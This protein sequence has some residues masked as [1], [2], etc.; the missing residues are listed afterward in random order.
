[1]KT[2]N[3]LV[4]GDVLYVLYF[5][6]EENRF[7]TY[8]LH[9]DKVTY[10][11]DDEECEDVKV[12]YECNPLTHKYVIW[13]GVALTEINESFY[14]IRDGLFVSTNKDDIIQHLKEYQ[15][16]LNDIINYANENL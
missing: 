15:S 5:K 1:M 16:R 3:E 11:Y 4:E 13:Y 10:E 2:F 8:K 6:L 7:W 14:I 9:I 12:F